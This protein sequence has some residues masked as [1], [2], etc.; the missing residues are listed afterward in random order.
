MRERF[1]FKVKDGYL[2]VYEREP[3]D[4]GFAWRLVGRIK[5]EKP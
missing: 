5:M 3:T 2:L 4:E 1:L